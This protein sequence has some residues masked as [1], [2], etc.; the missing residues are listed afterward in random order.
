MNVALSEDL[1]SAPSENSPHYDYALY[2]LRVRVG[3]KL[4]FDSSAI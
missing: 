3:V 4:T 1:V 2:G